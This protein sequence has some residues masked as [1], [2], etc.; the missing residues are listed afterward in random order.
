MT[1][2]ELLQKSRRALVSA[3]VLLREND[4]DGACNRAYYAMFCAARAALV[5]T[6]APEEAVRGKTH[7]GLHAAFN[8]FVVKPGLMAPSLGAAFRR[9]ERLR[10]VSDYIGE[11]IEPGQAARII[12]EAGQFIAAVEGLPRQV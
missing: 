11:A 5:L 3:D 10:L 12:R 2:S 9:E 4:V 1:A 7:H 6:G 8:L